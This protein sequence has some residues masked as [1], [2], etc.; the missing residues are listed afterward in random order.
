[1]Q[2]TFTNLE[3]VFDFVDRVRPGSPPGRMDPGELARILGNMVR[4][5]GSGS[6]YKI[7]AIKIYRAV[8]G[9]GLKEAKDAIERYS[10][11]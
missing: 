10:G 11:F 2:L 1:M 6:G 3:E 9:A 7:P 5:A 8:T 4:A